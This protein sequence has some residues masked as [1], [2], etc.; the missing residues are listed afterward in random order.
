MDTTQTPQP[1]TSGEEKPRRRFVRRMAIATV[2]AGV[3]SGLGIK[4][5]AQGG[6]HGGWHRGGFMGAALDPAMV[7][8]RL[9]RMLKHLYVE[10]DA[11]DA[12]KQQLAPIVKSAARDLLPVRAR[13]HDARRQAVELLSR[14][15]VDRA[16]LETLR[17][18]QLRLAEQASMRFTQ[19]LA[20]VADVLT[21]EQ[22]KQLAERIGRWHGR[23]G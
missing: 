5:F 19:A 13:L 2:I 18:D 8:E 21:P 3:A 11:S 9:D 22:R 15:S 17:A 1:S 20:D 23:R 4:A 12:Q 6:G 10:I 16:A 14:E 7:D